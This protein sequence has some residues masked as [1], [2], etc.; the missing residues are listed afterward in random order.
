M[1]INYKG[2]TT[3]KFEDIDCGDVF[4][5]E[6]GYYCI[7]TDFDDTAVCLDDGTTITIKNFEE[8]QLL[9]CELLIK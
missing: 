7:K 6:D 5:N 3:K 8:V 2:K 1:K 9:D 4:I